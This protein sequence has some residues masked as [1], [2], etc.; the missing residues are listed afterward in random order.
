MQAFRTAALEKEKSLL[1]K[2]V[3]FITVAFRLMYANDVCYDWIILSRLKHFL[4]FC[5]WMKTLE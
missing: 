5:T 1:L 3:V 4:T 2:Q